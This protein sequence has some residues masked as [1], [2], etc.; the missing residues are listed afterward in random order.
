MHC[1]EEI[2]SSGRGTSRARRALFLLSNNALAGILISIL[3][4]IE[5]REYHFHRF[6]MYTTMIV[7]P[8]LINFSFVWEIIFTICITN[9]C[10]SLLFVILLPDCQSLFKRRWPSVQQ[11]DNVNNS[12]AIDLLV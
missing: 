3:K 8:S 7:Y 5:T 9:V 10:S 2:M 11:V 4:D 6:V 1:R 12:K